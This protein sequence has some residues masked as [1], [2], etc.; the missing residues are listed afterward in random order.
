M[1]V[2]MAKSKYQSPV[3]YWQTTN[4]SS[5]PL[6][7]TIKAQIRDQLDVL[8]Q[9]EALEQ[10]EEMSFEELLNTTNGGK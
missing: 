3:K 9:V 8:E 6:G 10:A 4:S 2:T 1:E 7:F 5:L